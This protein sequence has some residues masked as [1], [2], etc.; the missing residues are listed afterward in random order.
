MSSTLQAPP[1]AS[2]PASS[3]KRSRRYVRLPYIRLNGAAMVALVAA[4]LSIIGI[5]YLV[6]TAHV[7]SLGYQLSALQNQRNDLAI[8]TAGIQAQVAQYESLN[9]IESIATKQL[10]MVPMQHYVFLNVPQ[11]AVTASQPAATTTVPA[12]ESLWHRFVRQITGTG[13]A[14]SPEKGPPALPIT[15]ESSKNTK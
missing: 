7:A 13:Q 1:R 11:Q 15:A 6:Q 5:L 12:K 3:P 2:K 4:A 8:Q 14:D 10:G 9:Q